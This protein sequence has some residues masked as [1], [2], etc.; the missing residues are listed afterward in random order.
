MWQYVTNEFL[1]NPTLQKLLNPCQFDITE[2]K[3]ERLTIYYCLFT[4]YM[5][6]FKGLFPCDICHTQ[7]PF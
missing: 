3:G 2:K 6:K 7:Y 5:N 4:H 1:V